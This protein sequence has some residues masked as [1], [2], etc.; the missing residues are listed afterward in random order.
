MGKEQEEV[1]EGGEGASSVALD[2]TQ[3]LLLLPEK[4]KAPEKEGGRN[5]GGEDHRWSTTDHPL[6]LEEK[7]GALFKSANLSSGEEDVLWKIEL[8]IEYSTFLYLCFKPVEKERMEESGFFFLKEKAIT[9]SPPYGD[10][11]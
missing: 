7:K 11:R 1:K 3:G 2:A 6:S 9:A 10:A 8:Y 4:T 5:E